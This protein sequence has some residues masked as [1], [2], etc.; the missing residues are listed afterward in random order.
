M[1]GQSIQ[2]LDFKRNSQTKQ[3][4]LGLLMKMRKYDFLKFNRWSK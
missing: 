1:M 4:I 3:A 2:Y